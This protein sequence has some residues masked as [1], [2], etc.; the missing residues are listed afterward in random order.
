MQILACEAML[1]QENLQLTYGSQ[2]PRV[3]E[4]APRA[5]PISHEWHNDR[6]VSESV[7]MLTHEYTPVSED[8]YLRL[9]A[10]SRN[11]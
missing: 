5:A 2:S 11:L 3:G 6:V 9:E 10:Q 1:E 7:A 8:E 4:R